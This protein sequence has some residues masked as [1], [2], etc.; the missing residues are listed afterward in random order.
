M[1][2]LVGSVAASGGYYLACA[3]NRIHAS[4]LALVGSIGVI[5]IRPNLA[6]L[7]RKLKIKRETVVRE[8]TRD[9]FSEAGPLSPASVKLMRDTMQSTYDL[10]LKRV[11][12]GRG[13]STKAVSRQAEGRVFGGRRF[14]AADMLDGEL[15][16]FEAL[17]EYRRLAGYPEHQ[18][19]RMNFYPEV[20]ADLRSLMTAPSLMGG[21]S[22]QFAGFE[23]LLAD[24]APLVSQLQQLQLN[25]DP[26]IPRTL[27]PWPL[28]LDNL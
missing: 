1:I 13:L 8:K 26:E 21:S 14:A 7:Y 23:Q 10:F 3:A 17:D 11:S 27:A 16:F 15:S 19:F 4:P 12:Q 22:S 28:V 18:Q 9:L 2:A 25:E 5:R 6:G 24:A 20:R